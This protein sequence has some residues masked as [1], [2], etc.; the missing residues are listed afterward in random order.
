MR[1]DNSNSISASMLGR[2]KLNGSKS[3]EAFH[4]QHTNDC[5]TP[6]RHDHKS[7]YLSNILSMILEITSPIMS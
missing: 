5:G 1:T 7:K 4:L 3:V 2:K 6:S